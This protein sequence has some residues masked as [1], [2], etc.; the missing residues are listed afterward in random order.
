MTAKG[1][2][3]PLASRQTRWAA[4]L[5]RTLLATPVTANAL[6]LI[7]I[8][9]AVLAGLALAAAPAR[10]WL[11]LLAAL[12]VQLRLL[13]NMMDGLVAVE[14]GRGSAVGALYNEAP[15]RLE[16]TAILVGFGYAAAWPELGFVAAILAVFT[17]YVRML[18]GALGLPQDFRGP[19]AKPHRMAAVTLGCILAALE[20]WIFGT[21]HAL[22]AIL[23]IVVAGTAWTGLR[24]LIVLGRLL[25]E[26]AP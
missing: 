24:R 13:C 18:G 23:A 25:R 22:R 5:L 4:A 1:E 8:L 16:D 19:M 10:P 20:A 7:G 26:R 12:G 6:S 2:R 17:A 11:Y 9:F 15:D 21:S 14:G 3:R